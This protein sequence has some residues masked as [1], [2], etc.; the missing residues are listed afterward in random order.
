MRPSE[1]AGFKILQVAGGT[2]YT[3]YTPHINIQ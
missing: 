2:L 3:F 1:T